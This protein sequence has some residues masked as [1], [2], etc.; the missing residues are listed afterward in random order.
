[1]LT[2]KAKMINGEM[3]DAG[4]PQLTAERGRARDLC[5]E[6]NASRDG[7]KSLRERILETLHG[8]GA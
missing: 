8:R 3:Y 5:R 2:E 6:L 1:M 7:E 4:D